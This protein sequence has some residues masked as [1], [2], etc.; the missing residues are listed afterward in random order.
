MNKLVPF[1]A[2]AFAVLAVFSST[3]D[4]AKKLTMTVNPAATGY[5][6]ADVADVPVAV[7]LS[8]RIS[9]FSY[10]D[11]Q[12]SDGGDL[13]FTDESGNALAHEIERWDE[14]GESVVW[15]KMP[16]FGV[17]RKLYAYYGGPANAQNAELANQFINFVLDYDNAM[18]ITVETCYSTPNAQVAIDVTAEGGEFEGIEW[19]VPRTGYEKDEIY[20]DNELLRTETPELLMKVKLQ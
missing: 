17:G 15:V 4:Y 19:Y 9:G 12:S 18:M 6:A 14:S 11:F 20:T 1:A 7:R 10:A 13:L 3:V 5:G 16:A 2:A 8:E